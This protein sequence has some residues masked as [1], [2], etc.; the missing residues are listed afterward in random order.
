MQ[1]NNISSPVYEIQVDRQVPIPMEDGTI[2]RA[3]VYRPTT[4][5]QFPVLVERVAYELTRRLRFS[6]LITR[7][8]DTSLSD[9]MCQSYTWEDGLTAFW[10]VP[11]VAFTKYKIRE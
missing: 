10:T 8:A 2:L 4:A 6:A 3:D 7:V 5:G 11:C 9:R 1:A